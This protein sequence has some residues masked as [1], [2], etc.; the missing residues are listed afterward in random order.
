[1]GNNKR[2]RSSQFP[3]ASKK[4][5]SK[6]AAVTNTAPPQSSS[7]T[8]KVVQP[9]HTS[10]SAH[11]HILAYMNKYKRDPKTP[12]TLTDNEMVAV[13][14][15][16]QHLRVFGLLSAAGFVKQAN[17]QSGDTKEKRRPVWEL[18]LCQLLNDPE[19]SDAETLKSAIIDMAKNRPAEYMALW[20]RALLFSKHWNFW[21][22]AYQ[23]PKS[24]EA[25]QE[26]SA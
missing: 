2:K 8:V 24:N 12:K 6:A 25:T 11:E 21:A 15:L 7:K 10:L 3:S 20:R 26:T 19:I 4:G 16:S 14:Q 18:L 1:M 22:R 5:P 23:A 13:L 9:E 17:Q